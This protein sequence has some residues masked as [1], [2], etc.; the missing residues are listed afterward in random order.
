MVPHGRETRQ[1]PYHRGRSRSGRDLRTHGPPTTRHAE[2][3][4]QHGT[5]S[6]R[7]V[8]HR[9]RRR[10]VLRSPRSRWQRGT[11][12]NTNKL[13]RQYL[14]KG[15]NLSTPSQD[16]LD[17]IATK[18][19][20]RPRKCLGF[21][22]PVESVALTGRIPGGPLEDVD[23]LKQTAVLP[24]QCGQFLAFA[25]GQAV[26]LARIDLGLLRPVTHRGLGRIEVLGDLTDRAVTA[27]AQLDDL[28]L[29]LGRERATR[30]R[31]LLPHALHDGH[32]PEAEPL[33]SDVRQ[34]GS[35]PTPTSAQPQLPLPS[36]SSRYE[37]R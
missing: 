34:S 31:L 7:A 15:T 30:A 22:T 37:G 27:S 6:P 8:H 19:N 32:P 35:S 33:I 2:L 3:G 9:Y 14:P 24:P 36:R 18:L 29:E 17:A 10:R 13:L 20:N 12:E 28:R 11:T 23:V 5:G 26:P 1:P 16:D 21:H 25:A 4:S